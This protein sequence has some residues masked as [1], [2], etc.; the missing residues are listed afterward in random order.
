MKT[1]L[2]IITLALFSTFVFAQNEIESNTET[3]ERI[4][5]PEFTGIKKSI[6]IIDYLKYNITYPEIAL[7]WEVEGKVTIGFNVLATGK[8]TDFEV[9]ESLSHDCDQ[10]VISTL[11]TTK[12][13]WI[14]GTIDGE[15]VSMEREVTVYFKMADNDQD[16]YSGLYAQN[17]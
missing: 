2:L 4:S 7:K 8:L 15:P 14:P 3:P 9:V 1:Q 13:M 5:E 10:T 12:D 11:K 6:D 16:Q 17:D